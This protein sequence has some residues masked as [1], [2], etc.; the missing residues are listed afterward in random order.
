VLAALDDALGGLLERELG[1]PVRFDPPD[2][3]W[4]GA[5]PGLGLFLHDVRP[6]PDAGAR[7]WT[8]HSRDGTAERVPPPR[9]LLAAYAVTA[10]AE[11]VRGEHALLSRAMAVVDAHP[12][13]GEHA[14]LSRVMAVVDAH[15]V[16]VDGGLRAD[17]TLAEPP[18]L[19]DPLKLVLGL[20][21]RV[22]LEAGR[23]VA[24]GPAGS[25]PDVRIGPG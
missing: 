15:P 4:E 16:L 12:V 3:G 2:R 17:V 6:A 13:R 23:A 19:G 8:T 25:A 20:R 10:W 21:A 1:V 22:L 5:L 24:R 11:D 7:Q 14:L 18:A 9:P